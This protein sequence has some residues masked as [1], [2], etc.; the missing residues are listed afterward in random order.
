MMHGVT[1]RSY[2]MNMNPAPSPTVHVKALYN[3]HVRLWVMHS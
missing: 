1:D 3:E 2:I